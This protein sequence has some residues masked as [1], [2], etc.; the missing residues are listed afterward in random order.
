ME[1]PRGVNRLIVGALAAFILA[2]SVWS[3]FQKDFLVLLASAV[4]L[5]TVIVMCGVCVLVNIAIFAPLFR[6]LGKLDRWILRKRVGN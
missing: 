5:G 1:N 3:I 6:L 4:A 2:T